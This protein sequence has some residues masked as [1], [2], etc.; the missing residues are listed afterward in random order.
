MKVAVLL[1]GQLRSVDMVKYLH[2]NALIKQYNADVFLGI[3]LN[4]TYQNMHKNSN[5]FT[6]LEDLNK[7]NDFFKPIGIVRF[8]FFNVLF[9]FI[10]RTPFVVA[11]F[12]GVYHRLF[13]GEHN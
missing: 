5:T 9:N 7:A 2:M 4:N 10:H 6:T 1:T 13:I 3:D 11:D 8:V 12:V